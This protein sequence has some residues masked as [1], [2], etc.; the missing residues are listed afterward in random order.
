MPPVIFRVFVFPQGLCDFARNSCGIVFID[1]S[2][3]DNMKLTLEADYTL[4]IVSVLA[5]RGVLTDAKKIS[6]ST[7]VTL[8]FTLK[9]LHKLV[10]G[11]VAESH[12]GVNG[13]Y[14]L[15]IAPDKITL[16]TIIELVDGPI[17]ISRC[18]NDTE[19][20]SLNGVE[21]NSCA[22]HRA[23]KKVNDVL[24][25]QLDAITI[26]DIISDSKN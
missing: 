13:G 25:E 12:K 11:G 15:R 21:K 1:N 22:F 5:T 26:A 10:K 23:F 20:C 9:I 18:L 3:A 14:K 4:R 8:R 24:A 19:V 2:E 16:K 6:E 17:A 7:A